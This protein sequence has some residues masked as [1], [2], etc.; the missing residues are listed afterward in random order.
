MSGNKWQCAVIARNQFPGR[1]K[2]TPFGNKWNVS[3]HR[4]LMVMLG[5]EAALEE[6][7][8]CNPGR[9]GVPVRKVLRYTQV[10]CV[11]LFTFANLYSLRDLFTLSLH[12]LWRLSDGAT[13]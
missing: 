3:M 8:A 11:S 5:S 13:S 6:A 9:S 1:Y 7:H 4:L 12:K 2:Q 10:P